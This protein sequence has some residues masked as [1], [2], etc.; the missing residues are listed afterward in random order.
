[1]E[2]IQGERMKLPL[3]SGDEQDALTSWRKNLS[4]NAGI[5]KAIKRRYNKRVRKHLK[6]ETRDTI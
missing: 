6:T 5:R 3:K 4:F 2:S 1:M